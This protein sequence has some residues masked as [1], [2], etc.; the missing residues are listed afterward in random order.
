MEI[1]KG[2]S[3]TSDTDLVW[4]QYAYDLALQAQQE[5]EVPVGAVLVKDNKV[6]GE[7]WN[8]PILNHDPTAH[9]EIMA[10]RDAA[11]KIQNY[12]LIETTLYVTLE[13]CVMCAGAIIHARVKRV[14]FATKD[15]RSGAAGS[16]FSV[17]D[18][19]ELNHSVDVKHGILAE[20]CSLLLKNFFKEKRRK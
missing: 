14:V 19:S 4:M 1:S 13:P 6:M 17:F 18:S 20:Q 10:I 3:N 15:P 16:A 2:I 7:G 5:G 11:I 12:R 8:K 9:A